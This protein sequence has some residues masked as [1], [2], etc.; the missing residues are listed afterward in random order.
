MLIENLLELFYS[1]RLVRLIIEIKYLNLNL[2]ETKQ[3]NYY[4]K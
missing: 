4:L 3:F 2:K 1:F